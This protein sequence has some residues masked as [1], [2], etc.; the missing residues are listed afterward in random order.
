MCSYTWPA[1]DLSSGKS[2]LV[3]G[4][5]QVRDFTFTRQVIGIVMDLPHK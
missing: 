2:V 4:N 5:N 3:L 1:Y